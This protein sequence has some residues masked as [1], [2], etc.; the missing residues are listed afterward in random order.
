LAEIST[1]F[2]EL[3]NRIS[4][5]GFRLN[6]E[7]LKVI[8][9]KIEIL[10]TLTEELSEELDNLALKEGRREFPREASFIPIARNQI[11]KWEEILKQK[12]VY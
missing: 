1:D 4:F 10:K 9:E 11:K 2:T 7:E 5:E 12:G 3:E 6:G 8:K